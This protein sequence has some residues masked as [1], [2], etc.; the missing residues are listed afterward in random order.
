MLVA[1]YHAGEPFYA[2]TGAG[3]STGSG[4]PDFRSAKGLWNDQDAMAA[5]SIAGFCERPDTIWELYVDGFDAVNPS[6]NAGH[7]AMARLQ[8]LGLIS[9]IVTQNVDAL[10]EQAG[11]HD[12]HHLHGDLS[13][14]FCLDCD[15]RWP[16]D[17]ARVHRSATG[18]VMRC[19]DCDTP[20][21]PSITLFDQML[22]LEPWDR[23]EAVAK[24]AGGV[25]VAGTSLAVAPARFIPLMTVDRPR[26][27]VVIAQSATEMDHLV[28]HGDVRIHADCTKVL[29]AIT[30]LC[31]ILLDGDDFF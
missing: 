7:V 24:R 11:S 13:Q 18:E 19:P 22:P 30:Q 6:P 31:E 15:R 29:P 20:L 12:V 14:A 4:L 17:E 16:L 26:P 1:A 3:I 21:Q 9:E 23:S 5:S 2:F 27:W 28:G 25:L 8:Q 10:H